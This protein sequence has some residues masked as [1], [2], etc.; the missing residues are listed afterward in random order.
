MFLDRLGDE[1]VKQFDKFIL[2]SKSPQRFEIFQQMGVLGRLG[3][4]RFF[5]IPSKFKEDLDKTKFAKPQ[6]YVL[7]T[8]KRKALNIEKNMFVHQE[9]D[10]IVC[11]DTIIAFNGKILEKPKDEA[12]AKRTLKM[13]SGNTHTVYTGVVMRYL[14]HKNER[15]ES[16]FVEGTSVE[17]MEMSE[18][19]IDAYVATKDPMDKAGSY[20]IQSSGGA[21]VKRI[22]GDYYNV[23]GFPFNRF[24][25]EMGRIMDELAAHGERPEAKDIFESFRN[26]D[27]NSPE[28]MM[29]VDEMMSHWRDQM[30]SSGILTEAQVNALKAQPKMQSEAIAFVKKN[31]EKLSEEFKIMGEGFTGDAQLA[32]N[33]KKMSKNIDE[34]KD[35]PQYIHSDD[36]MNKIEKEHGKMLNLLK[37]QQDRLQEKIKRDMN[38]VNQAGLD[39][40]DQ[41]ASLAKE[42][43]LNSGV[44]QSADTGDNPLSSSMSEINK[45][46][47]NLMSSVGNLDAKLS[48]SNTNVATPGGINTENSTPDIEVVP[49]DESK[50]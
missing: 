30:L 45:M 33:F 1:F 49:D 46:M 7:E 36:A 39:E 5:I 47:S 34:V 2:G 22:D 19:M 40:Q 8:A 10:L 25:R 27:V 32:E 48:S 28:Y 35:L 20:G 43:G 6:D 12:D 3:Q 37:E 21:F 31:L 23:V 17:F 11:A 24:A 44:D 4:T 26:A 14:D 13:L 42:L 15:V 18:S 38:F 16:S 50:A 41:I 29:Q 9:K